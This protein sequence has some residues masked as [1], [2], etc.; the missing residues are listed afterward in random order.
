MAADQIYDVFL[1][2]A[3]ADAAWVEGLARKLD[4]AGFSVWF[5]R[6]ALVPGELFQSGMAQGLEQARACLVCASRETPSGWLEQEIQHA[7]NR[8]AAE[9]GF[10]VIP[11]LIPG[12][13]EEALTPYLKLRT[14]VDLRGGLE[15]E[16]A[17]ERLVAGI[18]GRP[19][20]PGAG[21][22]PGTALPRA[23][24]AALDRYRALIRRR[25]AT[26]RVLGHPRPVPLEGV[27]T[28]VYLLDWPTALRRFDLDQLLEDPLLLKPSERIDG[29]ELV[30]GPEGQRL[31]ILG[32]PGAGETTVLKYLLAARVV[33]LGPAV[34]R[35]PG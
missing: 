10:R 26:L 13:D 21:A 25:H 12:A 28:D 9:P 5:D 30:R 7:L 14:W 33:G 3:H 34:A 22:R 17:F 24:E 2:H 6:W 20:G 31:F 4:D 23:R 35:V 29:L 27:F 11:V 16:V 8:Q 19:P 1:S 15:D 32:K 18:E